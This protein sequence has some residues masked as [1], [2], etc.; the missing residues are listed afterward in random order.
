MDDLENEENIKFD[1]GEELLNEYPELKILDGMTRKSARQDIFKEVLTISAAYR[2]LRT[3]ER[4][5]P[6]ITAGKSTICF[7]YIIDTVVQSLGELAMTK[8]YGNFVSKEISRGDEVARNIR[9]RIG[10]KVRGGDGVYR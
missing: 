10:H 6:D 5:L 7:E 9:E 1:L 3:I 8:K 2:N 4:C